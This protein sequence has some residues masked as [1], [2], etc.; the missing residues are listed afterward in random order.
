TDYTTSWSN[1]SSMNAGTY[2][3]TITGKGNYSGITK[4]T[5]RIKKAANSLKVKAKTA[6]VRFSKLTKTAQT[7]AVKKVMNISGARGKVTYKLV[8]VTKCCPAD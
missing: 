1:A 4:A 6:T 7:I 3:V 8:S 2:T 5:Y